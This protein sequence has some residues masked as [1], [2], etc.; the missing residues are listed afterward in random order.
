MPP[1]KMESLPFGYPVAHL[2]LGRTFKMSSFVEF[3][4]AQHQKHTYDL[5]IKRNLLFPACYLMNAFL[6]R[7]LWSHLF[8]SNP[9]HL[10]HFISVFLVLPLLP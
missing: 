4:K 7:A 6:Q 2:L 3:V 8:I 10:Q 5:A 9:P 1:W